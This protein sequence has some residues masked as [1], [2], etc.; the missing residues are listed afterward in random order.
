MPPP[1][2]RRES[3]PYAAL[4]IVFTA[5]FALVAAPLGSAFA[6][7][8]GTDTGPPIRNIEQLD[9]EQLLGTVT[10]ASRTEESVLTPPR[11]TCVTPCAAS[12]TTTASA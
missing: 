4:V 6:D 7:E 10:A 8:P 5:S 2:V 11:T 9:L 3:S 1:V 12:S